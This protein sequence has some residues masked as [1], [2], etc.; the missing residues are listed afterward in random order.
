VPVDR[1]DGV[2]ARVG[3]QDPLVLH[4]DGERVGQRVERL[5]VGS[6]AE[7]ALAV[8]VVLQLVLQQVVGLQHLPAGLGHDQRRRPHLGR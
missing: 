5:P 8:G 1:Q 7:L 2:G 4:V 3:D 6:R